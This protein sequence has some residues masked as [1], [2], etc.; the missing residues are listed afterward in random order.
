MFSASNRGSS[1][2]WIRC[3]PHNSA[4]AVKTACAYWELS[5]GKSP[6]DRADWKEIR[7]TLPPAQ[8]DPSFWGMTATQFLGAFNDN[9]YKQLV[10]FVCTDLYLQSTGG[11]SGDGYQAIAF[12][13]FSLPFVL[14][15]GIAGYLS[16]LYP[17][18]NVVIACKVAEIVVVLAGA[19]AF[20]FHTRVG[21]FVVLFMMGTHSAFFGPSKFGIL[22][23]A[24][25]SKDLPYVNGVF[26]M[27]TFLAIILGTVL[28]G[29]LKSISQPLQVTEGAAPLPGARNFVI[30]LWVASL[31]CVGTAVLGT[32]T[33]LMVRKTPAANPDLRFR[34]SAFG[35]DGVTWRLIRRDRVIF[36]V[37]MITSVFWMVGGAIQQAVNAF[38]KYQLAISDR[39]AGIMLSFVAIGI[40][41]GCLVAGRLS[42]GR[43]RFGIYKAGNV[44]IILSLV[45]L[46][47][48]GTWGPNYQKRLPEPAAATIV[49]VAATESETL[50]VAAPETKTGEKKATESS[51]PA[52]D[53]D[54]PVDAFEWSCRLLLLVVG[55]SAGLFTVP[56]QT[57]LQIRPPDEEK[58]RVIAA[59]NLINWIG[60]L[61]S[62]ALYFLVSFVI[63]QLNWPQSIHFV[64]CAGVLALLFLYRVA[65]TEPPTEMKTA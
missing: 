34:W 23:E 11:G 21:L 59:M 51:T 35:I 45:A 15:S 8:K 58:G 3:L 7:E 60:I 22:P 65:Y 17:K 38:S 44:G 62:A 64:M 10:L 50:P 24:F 1:L 63:D 55:I 56:L 25:R 52:V 46:W 27:T 39:R 57:F 47:A 36:N 49:A 2:A 16:D 61:L 33:A 42:K 28:A 32:M 20:F 18:R 41:I 29:E 14:F 37:L 4:C 54:R 26:I 30:P 13:V 9:L 43:I 31:A 48:L 40:T 19:S 6:L 12:A 5:M 53:P